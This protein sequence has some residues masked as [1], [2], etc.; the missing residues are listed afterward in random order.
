MN[1]SPLEMFAMYNSGSLFLRKYWE[2]PDSSD[3]LMSYL[4][5]ASSFVQYVLTTY[6][7][8]GVAQ[9]LSS[10]GCGQGT[11]EFRFRGDGIESL[12]F[13][14][15]CF[16]EAEATSPFRLGLLGLVWDLL[17]KYY[18]HHYL[19][20]FLICL[21]VCVHVGFHLGL[22]IAFSTLLSF[23]FMRTEQD[24]T[25]VLIWAGSV[26]GLIVLRFFLIN[27]NALLVT[28]V[29]V[30]VGVDL[31]RRIARRIHQVSYLFFA[32]HTPGSI[33]STF[34]KDVTSV[35][36]FLS[37]SMTTLL[38]AFLMLCTCIIYATS[39]SWAL[40]VP[41]AIAFVSSHTFT[42]WVSS[43]VA[44][45]NF[46]KAQALDKSVDLFKE[47]LDGY[48]ENRTYRCAA[49]W[50][51]EIESVL[52]CQYLPQARSSNNLSH[53]VIS[54]QTV[55][56][57][58][59]G[60][61]LMLGIVLLSTYKWVEFGRGLSVYLMYQLTLMA[62][63]SAIGHYNTVQNA[64]ISLSRINALLNN[65]THNMLELQL[66]DDTLGSALLRS[67]VSCRGRGGVPVEFN[68]VSFCYSPTAS[69]WTLCDMSF[70]VRAGERVVLVGE[71]GSGK[72]T[73]LNLLLQVI[74]PTSGS[75]YVAGRETTGR[76]D[77]T[78]VAVF[79]TNHIFGTTLG[80]NIRF[81]R[82]DAEDDEIEEAARLAGLHEWII[83]LPRGYETSVTSGGTSLSG[84]QRQRIA[85][86]RMLLSN[87]PVILLDEVTS[88]LDP[89]TG[90]RVFQTLL[91][92]TEGRTVIA[93]THQI[94][95]AKYF[96][97]IIVLSHGRIKEYG[98]HTELIC[99]QGM[100]HQLVLQEGGVVS[101]SRP[102]PIH[103]RHSLTHIINTPT[104]LIS[105]T[106][107]A[108][109]VATPLQTVSEEHSLLRT[110]VIF[111][112]SSHEKPLGSLSDS[113][114]R[115][116]LSVNIFPETLK[117]PSSTPYKI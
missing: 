31:R 104:P 6:G 48:K 92:A 95:Q 49:F 56:P 50:I 117:I 41:L 28:L 110:T 73:I 69:H 85:I 76:P 74:I 24:I 20:G 97:R 94:E 65:V 89:L 106:Y 114:S 93:V 81:G 15:K 51:S 82:L 17:K 43:F 42:M 21:L 40:G 66:P 3:E 67:R 103:R 101:P 27:L 39:V 30:Q 38:W 26:C 72:S 77:G 10:D 13:K 22:A 63:A 80:E 16:V 100:Y 2:R 52:H 70:R 71:T 4:T 59:I 23:G 14:W 62:I 112:P 108:P 75:V 105:V 29:T 54:F 79:Q 32:D 5:V 58:A 90:S 102:T 25:N 34:S 47:M 44:R 86:A 33:L 83:T 53:F 57:H 9:F 111:E 98:T 113:R 8:V 36:N 12:E 45:Y 96:D 64:R 91:K 87:A 19:K 68:R 84:G 18:L 88:A 60:L 116:N 46:S 78:A 35:E 115:Q 55:F 37:V 99:N 107:P 7:P 1:S 61:L 11:E 109:D